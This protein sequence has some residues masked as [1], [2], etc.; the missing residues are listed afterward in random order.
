MRIKF[1]NLKTYF[2]QTL[3][4]NQTSKID[5]QGVIQ[6]KWY[7]YEYARFL[8]ETVPGSDTQPTWEQNS[9]QQVKTTYNTIFRRAWIVIIREYLEY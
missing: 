3:K 9:Q 7:L 8:S 6:S 4:K 2:I 5:S 1:K